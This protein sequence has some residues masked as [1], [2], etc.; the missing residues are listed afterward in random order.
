MKAD[1]ISKKLFANLFLLGLVGTVILIASTSIKAQTVSS[2]TIN[3]Y[4]EK[5]REDASEYKEARKIVY[6]D[7][8]GDGVKD[9]VVQY[10]LE[11]AGGGNSWGQSLVV[12]LN[13]KGVFKL[14]DDE[15]VGGKF[16]RIFTLQK[17]VGKQIIGAT[18]TCPRGEPQGICKNPKKAQVKYVL[19]NGKLKEK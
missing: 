17:V 12:F 18:E 1:K 15:T 13:V 4:I 2:K 8:N 10:T 7:V 6:G 11:G 19:L 16:F 3:R 9:A 5:I 14:S